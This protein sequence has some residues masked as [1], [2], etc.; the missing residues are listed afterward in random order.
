MNI[1]EI[2]DF[3]AKELD[4]YARLTEAQ[5]LNHHL[6]KEGLFIA[7][8]PKVIMRALEDGYEPVSFLAEKSNMTGETLEV[9]EKCGDIPVY[10]AEFDVLTNLTGYMLTRGMLCAMKRKPLIDLQELLDKCERVVVLEDVMNPTNLGAIFRSA[11]A[12]GME[13]VLLTPG[14]SNPLYR[15]SSRVSMG[16]VFQ[17]PWT[18]LEDD[19]QIKLKDAGFKTAAMA[20]TDESVPIDHPDLIKEKKL[21]IVLG[22]EGDGLKPTTIANCDYTV[23]I[24][25]SNGVDSLNVAAAGAVAFW[26]LS[27]K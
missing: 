27:K 6:Q 11:A 23:K 7:E 19:W 8:S 13:A 25:M 2:T 26:Q 5:L 10:T 9:I 12:L 16:T 15:R 21:A 18:H 4:I 3:K 1:I 20:L 17:V 24:P 14:C 22:T